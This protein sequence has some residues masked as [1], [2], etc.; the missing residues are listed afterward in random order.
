MSGIRPRSLATGLAVAVVLA[1]CG[2]GPTEKPWQPGDPVTVDVSGAFPDGTTI[3]D[4]YG[5]TAIGTVA[6]GTIAVTPG[7]AGIA[8]LEKD[9]ATATPFRWDASTVYFVM[10]DRF[11]NGDPSNDGAYG[12]AKDGDQEIGTWHGG[13]LAGL[14]SK[15]DY[16]ASLGVTAI[17]ITPVVEQV[18]G[19]VAGGNGTFQNWGYAGYWALDIEFEPLPASPR[20]SSPDCEEMCGRGAMRVTGRHGFPRRRHP[21]QLGC[22]PAWRE[23]TESPTGAWSTTW[24]SGPRSRRTCSRSTQALPPRSSSTNSGSAAA[25]RGRT[26]P[27]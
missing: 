21:Q 18:H 13:D 26:S 24:T 17:W 27:S 14:T 19:W 23:R 10:T 16:I 1:A 2:C 6:G 20:K 3:R 25:A 11:M 7:A 22:L 4:A 12:R 9:G 15:L 8:L 5:G